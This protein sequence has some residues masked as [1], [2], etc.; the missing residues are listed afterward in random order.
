MKFVFFTPVRKT[1]A[2]GACSALISRKLLQEGHEVRVVRAETPV[3]QDVNIHDLGL[4]PIV[5]QDTDAVS[6]YIEQA[7]M[8]VYQIGNNYDYHAGCLHWL[9]KKSG[10]VILH[11]VYLGGL[12]H[13]GPHMGIA[14]ARSILKAWYG[15]E[16]AQDYFNIAHGD[17][18]EK[19]IS[20]AP[21][22]EWICA[23]A[24]AVITHSNW[25]IE[26]ILAA[27][28]GPIAV[29]PLAYDSSVLK[30]T[31]TPDLKEDGRF[32]ILTIGH[33]NPNKRVE[34]VIT[35]IGQS[36]LLKAH[37]TYQLAG[38]IRECDAQQLT[39]LANSLDVD[40]VISG[41]VEDSALLSALE[42]SDV[43]T[44]LRWPAL[45]SAS[46][47][48]ID[49]L[50]C[51]KPTIVTNTGFYKDIPDEYV[52]KIKH[53]QE[54]VEIQKTLEY[55]YKQP[56]KRKE[57]GLAAKVWAQKT[58]H[59]DNY[60]NQLQEV[61]HLTLKTRSVQETLDFISQTHARWSQDHPLA[62]SDD[63]QAAL[64]FFEST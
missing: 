2:I 7:D 9:E 24:Q 53:E 19:T 36:E 21:M 63:L 50:L 61:A 22:T 31:F 35:A 27:C 49:A 16:I 55:L 43:V 57:T 12:F 64:K 48:L 51:A 60:V 8:L 40:L 11:D 42:A 56:Q 39:A 58:F 20:T 5:W 52:F 33:M 1:S 23:M 18:I 47:S 13:V 10:I 15:Q 46:A 45:E 41:R 62:F 14:K 17:F 59:I 44:C 28:P 34:S 25:G 30:H 3:E 38:P 4:T 26:R 54:V 37:T 6:A 32:R 29:V